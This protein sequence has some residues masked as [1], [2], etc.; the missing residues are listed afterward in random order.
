MIMLLITVIL[1]LL[2]YIIFLI[3]EIRNINSQL[4]YIHDNDTNAEITHVSKLRIFKSFVAKTNR[5]LRDVKDQQ[6]NRVQQERELYQTISSLSHDL[7][8]P[9]TTA[10]GYASLCRNQH[11]D[12]TLTDKI[13]TS[14]NETT[15]Y[16][17]YIVDYTSLSE[18]E[19]SLNLEV[20]DVTEFITQRVLQYYDSLTQ[21]QIDV[22]LDLQPNVTFIT[23]PIVL[24]RIITNLIGNVLKY[25]RKSCHFALVQTD[26]YSIS[27]TVSNTTLADSVDLDTITQRFVTHDSSRQNKSVGLGLSIVD[28]CC[29]ILNG[30]MDLDYSDQIF[31]ASIT[32]KNI[33]QP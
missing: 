30:T 7:R 4:D 11:P 16:L 25:G 2:A 21:A 22:T 20:I 17:D 31:T 3:M 27:L 6:R 15:E 8:T 24:K 10:Y 19:M 29:Q 5:I 32:L 12:N 9:L 26:P 23:D 13:L 18:K 28:K 33:A 1:A 14:L